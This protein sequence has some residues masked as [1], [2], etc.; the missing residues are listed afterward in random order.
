MFSIEIIFF[1]R[2]IESKVECI[3]KNIVSDDLEDCMPCKP[4]FLPIASV[5]NLLHFED[6]ISTTEFASTVGLFLHFQF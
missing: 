5:D 1:Y 4:K 6:N 3:M 2:N